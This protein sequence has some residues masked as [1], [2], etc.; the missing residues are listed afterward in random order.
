MEDIDKLKEEIKMLKHKIK[1]YEIST[2]QDYEKML[3]LMKEI[4][5]YKKERAKIILYTI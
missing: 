2:K 5:K 1:L 4:D 3:E